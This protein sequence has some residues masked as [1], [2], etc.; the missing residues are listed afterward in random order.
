MSI[1]EWIKQLPSGVLGMVAGVFIYLT[2]SCL[3]RV[4]EKWW[5]RVLCLAGCWIASFTVIFIGDLV[6]LS[7]SIALFLFI[8]W[9]TC[10]GSF[11]KKVTLGLILSSSIFAF[12]ALY[13]NCL[14]FL[15]HHCGMDEFYGRMYTVGRLIFAVFL[16]LVVRFRRPEKEFELSPSLWRVMLVLTLT[17]LAVLASAILLRSPYGNIASTVIADGVLFLVVM[18]SFAGLLRALTVLESQQRLER[19]NTLVL[20]NQKYYENMELQQFEIRRLRH[21]M[22]NHLQALLAL[23]EQQREEYVKGMLDNPALAQTLSWCGDPTVNAVL[24]AKDSLMRQKKVRFSAKLDIKGELP[25]QKADVCAIFANALDNAVEA[26]MELE[27]S[28][29][30]VSLEARLGKGILAVNIKNACK[31]E[32]GKEKAEN[33][34]VKGSIWLPRTTK[35]DVENHGFGLASIQKTVKKYGGN[36]EIKREAQSFNLFLYLPVE[37]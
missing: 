24:T 21:D 8:I 6:N 26:C 29:R 20:M 12:N 11:L 19:E 1:L 16:Y 36:M 33:T 13:D 7:C 25:F 28:L 3:V 4:K 14:G 34:K 35:K 9:I 5:C 30:E 10:K 17:P 37:K 31:G 18:L 27:E 32:V 15:A 2:L 23:P 22:T